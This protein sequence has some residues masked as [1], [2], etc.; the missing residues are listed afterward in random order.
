MPCT[1]GWTWW[2]A[3]VGRLAASSQAAAPV[4]VFSRSGGVCCCVAVCRVTPSSVYDVTT[5]AVVSFPNV[6]DVHAAHAEFLSRPHGVMQVIRKRMRQV[7]VC[8]PELKRHS[9][10]PVSLTVFA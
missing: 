2:A 7:R 1:C 4:A 9:T 6:H 8:L 3:G 5:Y 10:L